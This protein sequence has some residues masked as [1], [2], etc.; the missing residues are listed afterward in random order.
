MSK[1]SQMLLRSGAEVDS[2]VRYVCGATALAAAVGDVDR[3]RIAAAVRPAA[4][5][6]AP[7]ACRS[8]RTTSTPPAAIEV[9]GDEEAVEAAGA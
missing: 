9:V 3:D 4:N 1:P 6:A 8:R 2:P 7:S 5:P